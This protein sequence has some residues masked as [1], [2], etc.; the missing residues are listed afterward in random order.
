MQRVYL[1]R[2]NLLA[3][4][5]KLDR[6]RASPGSS[7]VTLVKCDTEHP[8]YPCS[9]VTI[10]TALEDEAYYTDRPPGDVHADDIPA[11]ATVCAHGNRPFECRA[12]ADALANRR[13]HVLPHC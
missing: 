7:S 10:V 5:S 13:Q 11:G 6:N 2:R 8:V 9:D 4:L 3:L 12:C 1:S